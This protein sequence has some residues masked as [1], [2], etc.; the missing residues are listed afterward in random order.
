[1]DPDEAAHYEPPHLN[2]HSLQIYVFMFDTQL[3]RHHKADDKIN[4]HKN[5]NNCLFQVSC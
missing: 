2:F 5:F 1:M 4:F 3:F